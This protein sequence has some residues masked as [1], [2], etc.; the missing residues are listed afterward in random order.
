ML[1][2]CPVIPINEIVML[3]SESEFKLVRNQSG[4]RVRGVLWRCAHRDELEGFAHSWNDGENSSNSSL[5]RRV[6]PVRRSI[7]R[8]VS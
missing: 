1:L 8:R 3:V 6:T 5:L 7:S 4:W 2:T